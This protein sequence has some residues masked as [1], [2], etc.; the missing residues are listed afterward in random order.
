ML[1]EK[2]IMTGS[3]VVEHGRLKELDRERKPDCV[4]NEMDSLGLSQKDAQFKNKW[5]GELRGQPANKFTWENGSYFCVS[6]VRK[7]PFENI[8]DD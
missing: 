8:C 5:K 4:K 3:N 2:M 6:Y 7:Y 1:N